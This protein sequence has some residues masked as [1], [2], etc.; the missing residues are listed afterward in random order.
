MVLSPSSADC[1]LTTKLPARGQAHLQV[2]IFKRFPLMRKKLHSSNGL[3]PP[4][5]A[6]WGNR[7]L[8]FGRAGSGMSTACCTKRTKE[9]KRQR[10][11]LPARSHSQR[12]DNRRELTADTSLERSASAVRRPS[13]ASAQ[14]ARLGRSSVGTTTRPRR[15]LQR[16]Q[17][18]PKAAEAAPVVV[19]I[20]ARSV[21]REGSK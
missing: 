14:V 6:S 7:C 18:P 16:V 19:V 21:Y 17:R 9:C 20:C 4:L 3:A 10:F 2:R 5:L 1:L 8:A 13:P 11:R 12:H 15:L